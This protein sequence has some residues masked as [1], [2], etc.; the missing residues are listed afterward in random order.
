MY[1]T[2]TRTIDCSL[3]RVISYVVL[4]VLTP[5]QSVEYLS[6]TDL[7]G[8]LCKLPPGNADYATDLKREMYDS[9]AGESAL[10]A[11]GLV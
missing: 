4:N 9:M 7:F 10:S 5:L 8:Q 3:L 11:E 6:K 1:R 2:D